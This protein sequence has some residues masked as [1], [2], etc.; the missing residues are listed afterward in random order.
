MDYYNLT[1]VSYHKNKKLAISV[2]ECQFR[3]LTISTQNGNIPALSSLH[4]RNTPCQL[5]RLIPSNSISSP[6]SSGYPRCS[7]THP[8]RCAARSRKAG[9]RSNT[10]LTDITRRIRAA[11]VLP[12]ILP[13]GTACV[14][15]RCAWEM[16]SPP[17]YSN[18]GSSAIR[19]ADRSAKFRRTIASAI[20]RIESFRRPEPGPA[21]SFLRKNTC[22][23][24]KPDT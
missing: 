10:I 15:Y 16:R 9:P 22:P 23:L 24:T 19:T 6:S 2:R 17:A 21:F 18:G 1:T 3:K 13:A 5:T 8:L 12:A 11:A 14:R 4:K 20:P 7:V